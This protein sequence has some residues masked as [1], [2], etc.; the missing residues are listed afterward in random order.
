[1]ALQCAAE[2]E[3][4]RA[5]MIRFGILR[6]LSQTTGG[7]ASNH[8]KQRNGYGNTD[9]HYEQRPDAVQEI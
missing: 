6:G 2:I 3:H 9:A 5:G 1:V 8:V 4:G 7:M